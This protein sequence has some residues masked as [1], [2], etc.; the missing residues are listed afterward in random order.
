MVGRNAIGIIQ[1]GARGGDNAGGQRLRPCQR[2]GVGCGGRFP[3]LLTGIAD[4]NDNRRDN[5]DRRHH[6]RHEYDSEAAL[7]VSLAGTSKRAS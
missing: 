6:E 3:I 4:I 2:T 5:E 7:V 1:R